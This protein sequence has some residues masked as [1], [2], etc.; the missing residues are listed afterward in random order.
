[1]THL[2]TTVA[3]LA[4]TAGS[5]FAGSNYDKNAEVEASTEIETTAGAELNDA[6][7]ATEDFANDA[8]EATE[9][10]VDTTVNAASDAATA[11]GETAEDAAN[12]TADAIEGA[13]DYT[14]EAVDTDPAMDTEADASVMVAGDLI[15]KNVIEANG[16]VIGEID[17]VVRDGDDLSAVIGIGG[18][19]GL[20]EYTVAIPLNEFD[21][22]PEADALRL[23][24][25]TQEELEAQPE[26][27][28]SDVDSVPE[29]MQI[30]QLS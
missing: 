6:A 19:L 1:M 16:E 27:D 21:M 17:Y 18:F 24:E 25:W 7:E 29:D 12:A 4:L 5:A 20:G 11:V 3:I 26:F 23:A 22:A 15:G 28:E 9:D 10:A 8:A 13:A 14:A 2:K 30:D